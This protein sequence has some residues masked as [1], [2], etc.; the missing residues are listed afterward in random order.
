MKKERSCYSPV[1]K[2][3]FR[4]QFRQEMSISIYVYSM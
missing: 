1:D 2:R 3:Q 4:R